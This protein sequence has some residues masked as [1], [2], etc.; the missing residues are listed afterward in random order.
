MLGEEAD[1]NTG[2]TKVSNPRGETN[3]YEYELR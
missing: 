1:K 3:I 2:K